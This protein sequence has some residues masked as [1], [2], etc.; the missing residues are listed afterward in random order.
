[1]GHQTS[2]GN[3]RLGGFLTP[4]TGA[5]HDCSLRDEARWL[6]ERRTWCCR[7]RGKGCQIGAGPVAIA[8]AVEME[9]AVPPEVPGSEAFD[10]EAG[11]SNWEAGWSSPK[12]T[13]CCANKQKG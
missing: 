10:C 7:H 5:P 2:R 6:P 3:R 12:K 8:A 11:Y 9:T 1:M 13:W 4:S